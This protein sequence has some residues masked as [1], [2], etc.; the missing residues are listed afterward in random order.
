MQSIDELPTLRLVT[1]RRLVRR[2][3]PPI[4]FDQATPLGVVEDALAQ[5]PDATAVLVDTSRVYQ[6][7][8]RLPDLVFCDR[9][10]PAEEAMSIVTPV[11]FGEEDLAAARTAMS[12]ADTDRVL[13]IA[14][15]GELLGV[16]TE[17]DLDDRRRAA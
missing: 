12:S 11:L 9:T 16:L 15:D 17:R 10:A 5:V 6:G 4:V 3:V 2:T 13:V 8:L 14:P 7:T 1:L